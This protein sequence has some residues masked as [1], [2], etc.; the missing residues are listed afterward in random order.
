LLPAWLVRADVTRLH[1]RALS[2]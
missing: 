2:G 1:V